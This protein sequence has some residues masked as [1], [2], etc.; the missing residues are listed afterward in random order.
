MDYQSPLLRALLMGS[1]S[2][3]LG[4]AFLANA[5]DVSVAGK[6]PV[7]AHEVPGVTDAQLSA[8]FWIAQLREPDRV[9]LD[10]AMISARNANL[11]RVDPTMHDLHALPPAL[12]R[13]QVLAWINNLSVRPQH[14][15]FDHDG[16]PVDS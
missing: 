3:A 1:A 6:L 14:E 13:E 4:T 5:A 7:P 9:L 11:Q 10:A 8:E 15:L 12:S 2:L 16:K